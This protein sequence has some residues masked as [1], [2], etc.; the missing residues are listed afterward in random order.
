MSESKKKKSSLLSL[1]WLSNLTQPWV[2]VALFSAEQ[3]HNFQKTSF[4][5]MQYGMEQG[6]GLMT[7]GVNLM[8]KASNRSS[9]ILLE[10][11][12]KLDKNK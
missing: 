12:G 6:F 2:Q 1:S 5:Q 9:E 8:S 10:Q 3:V 4:E 7:K 11:L